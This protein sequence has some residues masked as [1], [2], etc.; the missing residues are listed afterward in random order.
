MNWALTRLDINYTIITARQ[1]HG[2]GIIAI[3]IEIWKQ[4]REQSNL[5]FVLFT[6]SFVSFLA[7]K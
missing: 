4:K 6:V 3:S 7:G 2:Y 5:S 1:I